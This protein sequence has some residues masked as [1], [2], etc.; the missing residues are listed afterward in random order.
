[1]TFHLQLDQINKM[2]T[3]NLMLK[4]TKVIRSES[5]DYKV[6]TNF[7]D[8]RSCHPIWLPDLLLYL[9]NLSKVNLTYS[10]ISLSLPIV[11]R[12]LTLPSNF[13][14]NSYILYRFM[15]LIR[16]SD[17]LFLMLAW[18]TSLCLPYFPT[19]MF[20]ALLYPLLLKANHRW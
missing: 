13:S 7:G 2:N 3:S 12:A 6:S 17:I 15:L 9:S 11:S 19:K 10:L 5:P 8:F 20:V 18:V 4:I 14:V 1:M 16:E